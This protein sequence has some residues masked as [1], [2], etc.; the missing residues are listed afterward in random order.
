MALLKLWLYVATLLLRLALCHSSIAVPPTSWENIEYK[1]LVDLSKS[2][3]QEIV[4]L[5]VRNT[6]N[7]PNSIYYFAFSNEIFE[8]IS[9]FTSA[10]QD[11]RVF[12]DSALYPDKSTLDDGRVV[13]Y[14]MVSLPTPIEPGETAGIVIRYSYYAGSTPFPEHIEMGSDQ[15]LLLET[16][17]LPMSAYS[18]LDYTL[19]FIGSN[20]FSELNAQEDEKLAGREEADAFTFGPWKDVEPFTDSSLKLVYQ[21]N[22]PL[23]RI[24]NLKRDLWVSHWASTLQFEE[25]Y[26]L[27]NDAAKLKNGFS[28]ADWMK[29]QH[30]LKPS[31]SLVALEMILPPEAEDH[32]Y[33]DLVGMVSTSRVLSNHYFLKP[34]FPLFGGWK[35]N[36]TIGW[37]NQLSQ[38]LHTDISKEEYVLSVPILNGPLDTFYDNVD[39]SVYLPEDA[40]VLD[41]FSPLPSKE[42]KITTKKSYF[43]LRDGHIKVSISLENLTD[44]VKNGEVLIRY[45]YTKVAFYKKVLSISSYVFVALMCFFFF[46]QID[47]TIKN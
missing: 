34:R 24:V 37:T 22:M 21:H 18:T 15:K 45:K 26:E 25:Y 1:R 29:G 38:F 44:E 6:A 32:Y 13:A 46:K 19:S 10:L 12:V 31:S 28:R 2:Y 30:A 5:T 36:F 35:F 20:S 39:F 33:T 27:I 42:T 3:T 17:K 41:V 16:G 7:E 47:L 8:K 14:G 9:L 43:D 11:K 23:A 4:E 40:E